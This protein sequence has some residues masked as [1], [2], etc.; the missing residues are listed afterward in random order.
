MAT[1]ANCK[2]EGVTV[3]HVRQCYGFAVDTAGLPVKTDAPPRVVKFRE[4]NSHSRNL[5]ESDR[6]YLNVDYDEREKAK[7]FFAARW[8]GIR[9]QW[10]VGKDANFEAMPKS[11]YPTAQ[12]H[13]KARSTSD[14]P[15]G[16]Y[17]T[18]RDGNTSQFFMVYETQSGYKAAKLLEL[19]S[20]EYSKMAAGE[21]PA[22]GVTWG[23]WVYVGSPAKHGLSEENRL[24]D[25]Q[26]AA[27]GSIYGWCGICGR[28]L[29]N[30]ESKARGIGPVCAGKMGL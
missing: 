13:S 19:T 15:D 26:A 2:A 8:D 22:D 11:W 18:S 6:V 4:G 21:S 7:K 23:E 3:A 10:Y 5:E 17:E 30:E 29:R 14:L 25:E 9:R 27:F 1:C 12:D 28:T 16:I 24:S 20:E